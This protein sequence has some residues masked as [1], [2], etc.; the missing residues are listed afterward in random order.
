VNVVHQSFRQR[1]ECKLASVNHRSAWAWKPHPQRDTQRLEGRTVASV[2]IS[3]QWSKL[4]P[5]NRIASHRVEWE[6]KHKPDLSR[7][8]PR[9]E[10]C[11][12]W[13]RS[14]WAKDM[15]PSG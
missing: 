11:E 6:M 7:D 1:K 8:H 9:W 14:N 4:F 13:N 15:G 5:C 3:I 10:I 12:R 2:T